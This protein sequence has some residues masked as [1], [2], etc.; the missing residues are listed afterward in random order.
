M[1]KAIDQ[2]GTE[3]QTKFCVRILQVSDKMVCV[4]FQKL[5]GIHFNFYNQYK[6]IIGELGFVNDEVLDNSIMATAH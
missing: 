1:V 2:N 6:E 4:E 3:N 5:E